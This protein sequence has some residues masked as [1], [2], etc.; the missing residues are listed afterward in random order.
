MRRGLMR[1]AR[2]LVALAAILALALA[3]G[4]ATGSIPSGDG[5][6]HGCYKA[7]PDGNLRV[8]DA[9]QGQVCKNNETALNWNQRGPAGPPGPQGPPGPPGAKGDR[10]PTGATGPAG[11]GGKVFETFKDLSGVPDGNETTVASLALPTGTYV[12]FAKGSVRNFD[13]SANWL[14]RLKRTLGVFD[15]TRTE[16]HSVTAPETAVVT[17]EAIVTLSFPTTV[18]MTCE[19]GV[20]ESFVE[21]IKLVAIEA[22]S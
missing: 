21:N 19:S 17:L 13:N 3:V 20:P 5:T 4:V 2:T 9:D 1:G 18:D 12:V 22:V 6:I 7:P 15:Y 14:C 16:T 10:G 8:I 11:V